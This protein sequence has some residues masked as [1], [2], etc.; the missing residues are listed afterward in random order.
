MERYDEA[1]HMFENIR[2][3][4]KIK[5]DYDGIA[6]TNRSLG[7]IAVDQERYADAEQYYL[8]AI[9]AFKK[10]GDEGRIFYTTSDLAQVYG[11]QNKLDDSYKASLQTLE[12]SR[13]SGLK[14]EE[15]WSLAMIGFYHNA[16]GNPSKGLQFCREAWALIQ[17]ENNRDVYQV[18]CECLVESYEMLENYAKALEF[19]RVLQQQKESVSVQNQEREIAQVEANF[20]IEK[21]RELAALEQ[22]TQQLAFNSDLS[23]QKNIRN[24]LVLSMLALASI[25]FLIWRASHQRKKANA[26]LSQ[27]NDQIQTALNEKDLL[28]REIHHRVKNNLQVVSSLLSLQSAYVDDENA[29]VAIN[30]GRDRVQSMALIH[31]N[32]YREDNLTGIEIHKY[33]EKLIEGLFESYNIHPD[34]IKLAMSIEELN[35]DV[36]TVIPLGLVVNELVS[37]A[38]K[39]AFPGDRHGTISISLK[40]ENELLLLSVADDGVGIN[41]QWKEENDSF[42]YQLIHAFKEKLEA[43][44]DV[45]SIAGTAVTLSIRDYQ[46]AG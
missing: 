31:Q 36:D 35:L 2:S 46:K 11:K 26:L 22:E 34:R 40:E 23:K 25:L 28:L 29:L 32:L 9:E 44:L 7:H 10:S 42:G 43:D 41:E 39:Y 37:N 12:Y 24:L 38:L 45:S 1:S 16:I 17:Q 18:T 14:Y 19:Y 3:A 20:Q 15:A 21:E 8:E 27:K 33:F 6:F 4:S 5:Q 13:K 30:E